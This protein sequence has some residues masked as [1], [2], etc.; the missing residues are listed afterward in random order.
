MS[1][2]K[3]VDRTIAQFPRA[4]ADGYN[5]V[6]FGSNVAPAKAAE[7]KQ[8]AK[9]STGWA[10]S[11]WSWAAAH[12]HNDAEGLLSQDAL[13][14]AHGGTAAFQPDNPT[15]VVNGDFED[16]DRQPLQRL[17][18]PG[19]RGRDHV[20]G[21]R[22]HARRQDLAADGE[23]RQERRPALPH[24]AADQA[25]AA[26]PVPRLRSGSR[27]RIWRAGSTPEV[28]LLTADGAERHQLPDLP[29]RRGRRT[30]STTIWPSTA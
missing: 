4:Q 18:L 19:R 15:Q 16:V 30:G 23:H 14:V 13:F 17:G 29:L 6:V 22:R 7:F 28:K 5:A 27:R 25:P 2:P 9:A 26:P 21:S 11:R 1:D 24:H 3:Q 12:D 20:R 10:W 8:A